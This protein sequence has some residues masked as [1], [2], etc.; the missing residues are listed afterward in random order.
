M[1]IESPASFVKG[2]WDWGFLDECFS[3]KIKVTDIDGAVERNGYFL[4]LEA[5]SPNV[6]VKRGQMIMFDSMVA[7][8]KFTVL[9]LWG[10]TNFPT[11]YQLLT[12]KGKGQIKSCNRERIIKIVSAW[13]DFADSK[14][15]A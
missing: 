8:G 11:Q 14:F 4:V 5:K 13:F 12:S 2:L 9:I 1:S 10:E 15:H 7:T 6:P 3:G